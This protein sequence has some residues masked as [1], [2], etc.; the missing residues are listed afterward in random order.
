[1][2]CAS[3]V[4]M[5][6]QMAYDASLVRD[7][8]SVFVRAVFFSLRRR[9]KQTRGDARCG[10][11]T[12]IQ[13][14]GGALNLNVHLHTLAL[15][16][17]YVRDEADPRRLRF[18]P[19]PPPTDDEVELVATRV[20]RSLVRLAKRRGLDTGEE[21]LGTEALHDEDSPLVDLY[22]ASVR[23]R[24][25]TGRR[26][27]R[28]VRRLGDRVDPEALP[29]D[30]YVPRCATVQGVSVHANVLVAARDRERLERLARYAARPALA[31]ERL[32]RRDD[33][34]LVYELRNRW[35]DGTT[36]VVFEPLELIEKLA[37]LVP[38]PRVNL[39]RYH[40]ILAPAARDRWQVI[41][42]EAEPEAEPEPGRSPATAEGDAPGQRGGQSRRPRNYTWAE[43]MRRVFAADVLV[44]PDCHSPMR[45]LAAIHPPEATRAILEHLGLSGRSPPLTPAAAHLE[46]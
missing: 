8:L 27:G 43:L 20:A 2:W 35:R 41:P 21:P 13:R 10:A 25:A 44:C 1:M 12:F 19:L 46:T 18:E 9:A 16:G 32:T 29:L 28:R 7:V 5:R 34:L 6:F 24:V 30:R 11:V 15:D 40:G 33:G 14:F 26:A 31:G 23:S 38:P 36:R 22:G 45:I 17:V 39:V 37:A 42:R 4:S 3:S